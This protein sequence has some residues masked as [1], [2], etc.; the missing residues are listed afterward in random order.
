MDDVPAMGRAHAAPLDLDAPTAHAGHLTCSICRRRL[1]K[2]LFFVEETGD[3]PE[4][5]RSWVLCEACDEAVHQQMDLSPLRSSL[6]LRVAV[7]LV[8]AERS[9]EARRGQFGQLS[10]EQWAKVFLWLFPITMIVHLAVIVAIAGW[11]K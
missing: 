5:R 1:G 9:P 11:F 4:P 6:R 3:V 8:A 2:S 7:G 10:D